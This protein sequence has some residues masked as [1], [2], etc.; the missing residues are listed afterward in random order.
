MTYDYYG[1]WS[2]TTGEHSPLY[3]SSLDSDYERKYLNINASIHNWV[4]AGAPKSI[5]ALGIP[6]YGRTFTLADPLVN[7]IHAPSTGGGS[8]LAPT[9]YQ[10]KHTDV[11][12]Q[13]RNCI[14]YKTD[15]QKLLKLHYSME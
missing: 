4:E 6:F 7:G 13:F 2:N 14:Y 3:P 9:Y 8:P 10:V 12:S 5:L 15:S 11:T 1:S